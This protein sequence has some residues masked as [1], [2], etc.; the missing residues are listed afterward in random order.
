[1]QPGSETQ[2]VHRDPFRSSVPSFPINQR[3]HVKLIGRDQCFGIRLLL[4]NEHDDD[5]TNKQRWPRNTLRKKEK[6]KKDNGTTS[7]ESLNDTVLSCSS[8][9]R[10]DFFRNEENFDSAIIS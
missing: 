2:P 7:R 3:R 1:M 10:K 8:V 5:A 9:F 6:K 4:R